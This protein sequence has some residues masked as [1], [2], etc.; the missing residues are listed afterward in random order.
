MLI[1]GSPAK[2]VFGLKSSSEIFGNAAAAPDIA[3]LI[4][5]MIEAIA[6]LADRVAALEDAARA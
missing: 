2:N 4:K 3:P 5:S 1:D 6:E